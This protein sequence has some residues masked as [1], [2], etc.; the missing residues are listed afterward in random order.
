MSPSQYYLHKLIKDTIQY[1][2]HRKIC[3]D[4]V[5][6]ALHWIKNSVIDQPSFSIR[7]SLLGVRMYDEYTTSNVE[8][9]HSIIKSNSVGLTANS[10]VTNMF[11][12]TDLNAEKRS[13]QRHIFQSNDI[14]CTNVQTKCQASRV[15]VKCCYEQ[16]LKRVEL[17][18]KCI[19]KQTDSRHWIVIYQST[20]TNGKHH[21]HILPK[22]KRKRF[23]TLSLGK[24]LFKILH[25]Y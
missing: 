23:V 24:F 7:S 4:Q 25:Y 6:N 19:S 8:S 20:T 15:F 10:T 14:L 11:E 18:Q 2:D 22:I 9:E 5:E 1:K 16:I 21:L 17:T 12:K 13:Q 3:L